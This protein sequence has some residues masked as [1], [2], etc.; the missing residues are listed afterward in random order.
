M[1]RVYLTGRI[2]VEEDGKVII[3]ES[4]FRARQDRLAFAYLACE[5][6]QPVPRE[7]LAAVIWPN[8]MPPAW[9]IAI[10]S[11]I[12]RLRRLLA[13]DA[14][15]AHSISV[16]SAFGQYQM[17]LP[18]DTWVDMEA[19]AEA[20]DIAEGALRAGDP[21]R[22]FGPASVALIIAKR[23]FLSASDGDWA[24]VQ[25]GKLERTLLRALESLSRI[26]LATGE[27]NLAVESATQAISV[28]PFRESSYQLLM[29]ALEATGNR[30]E[31]VRTYHHLR[32]LLS[33]ELGTDPSTETEVLYL[34]LLG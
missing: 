21:Q 18:A 27:P 3:S 16:L 9:G 17:Q 22:A 8:E 19:A 30:P 7:R 5:R 6:A 24:A 29:Q 4:E 11:V 1:I 12:S 23:P 26:W 25:R 14:L 20:I 15:K 10:S 34:R 28:D 2:C 33:E 31:A 13:C 32:Q